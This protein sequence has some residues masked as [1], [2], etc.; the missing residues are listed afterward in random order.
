MRE[1]IDK[2]VLDERFQAPI[3]EVDLSH[4]MRCP[5]CRKPVLKGKIESGSAFET[6][7]S[8]CKKFFKVKIL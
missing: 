4:V 2:T 1:P 6:R 5:F 7:C 8:K 3:I